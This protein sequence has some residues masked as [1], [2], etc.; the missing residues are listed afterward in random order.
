[1]FICRQ[2]IK[3]LRYAVLVIALCL[4]MTSCGHEKVLH[5]NP[6]MQ[7]ELDARKPSEFP[8]YYPPDN[9]RR[10]CRGEHSPRWINTG[11]GHYRVCGICGKT[12]TA[13][14]KH[15]PDPG[16]E[17]TVKIAVIDG[18]E[19]V[20]KERICECRAIVEREYIPLS[21]DESTVKE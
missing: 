7:E 8:M 9:E 6:E 13:E 21:A 3:T 17:R 16:N 4:F 14:E 15:T 20:I 11:E 12:L 2:R 19:Y 18:R 1:M 5:T 10:E